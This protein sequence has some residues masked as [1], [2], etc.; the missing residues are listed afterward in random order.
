MDPE[1]MDFGD[2][3]YWAP[4]AMGLIWSLS[5]LLFALLFPSI[6]SFSRRSRSSDPSLADARHIALQHIS[7][8]KVLFSRSFALLTISRFTP[9]ESSDA[10]KRGMAY[11]INGA[12][13]I[14]FII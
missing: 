10:G 12:R 11:S 2:E 4:I 13:I 9:C 7:S 14:L 5:C 8:F 6:Y 3:C 1:S